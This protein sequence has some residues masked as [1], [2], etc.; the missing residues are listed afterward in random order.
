[1]GKIYRNNDRLKKTHD[2]ATIESQKMRFYCCV[3]G[4]K[5]YNIKIEIEAHII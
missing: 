4:E 5:E 1:M 2:N 3:I